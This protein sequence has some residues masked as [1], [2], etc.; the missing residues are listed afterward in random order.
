[1]NDII[2]GQA[3][4]HVI[5]H[6]G[7]LVT[8][9][10]VLQ[11]SGAIPRRV[12]PK[13]VSDEAVQF[14]PEEVELIAESMTAVPRSIG[15]SPHS[16][17]VEAGRCQQCPRPIA[18]EKLDQQRESPERRIL[19]TPVLVRKQPPFAGVYRDDRADDDRQQ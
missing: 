15:L 16:R 10:A 3:C 19:P 17:R 9:Q 11:V 2:L 1:M 12:K 7:G 13:L 4:R 5:V 8:E 6:A 18:Q 14:V